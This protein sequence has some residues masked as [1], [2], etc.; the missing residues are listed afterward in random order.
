MRIKNNK[1]LYKIVVEQTLDQ[2]SSG[3]LKV[4]HRFPPE[5]DYAATLGVSRFT[6]RQA[7]S[8]LEHAGI[9][10]RRKRGGTE[11]IAVKPAQRFNMQPTGIYNISGIIRET[12]FDLTDVSMVNSDAQADL[13]NYQN[14]S[15]Q[16]VC[17]T[18]TRTMY[19]QS[20][21]FVRSRI[22]IGSQFSE[23][24]VHAGDSPASIYQL[25]L[26]RY[27]ESMNRIKQRYSAQL[28]SDEIGNTLGLQPGAPVIS[29]V[30]E[31]F[32]D[33]GELLELAESMFDPTRFKLDIDIGVVDK[34]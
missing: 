7:F 4:G 17:C 8:Q 30:A 16:W 23:I 14:E 1:P 15:S 32:N 19:D 29:H 24:G 34:L 20:T 10:K 27:G 6:L 5:A 18:G 33:N 28:C 11:V 2:L 12:Q 26:D 3:E 25:I 31:M 13:C 9:I 22:F 21:P